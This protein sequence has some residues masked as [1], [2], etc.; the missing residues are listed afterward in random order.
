[1]RSPFGN[2]A[3]SRGLVIPVD[4]PLPSDVLPLCGGA[5]TVDSMMSAYN[6]VAMTSPAGGGNNVFAAS[7]G[8]GEGVGVFVGFALGVAVGDDVGDADGDDVGV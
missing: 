1:M 3:S 5:A 6:P 7:V 4:A 8:D 2:A